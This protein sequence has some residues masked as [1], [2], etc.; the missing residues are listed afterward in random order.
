METGGKADAQARLSTGLGAQ[1]YT[2]SGA[3]S[4]H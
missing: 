1:R 2:F 4:G 3:L